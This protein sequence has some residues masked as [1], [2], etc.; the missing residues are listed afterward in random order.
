MIL[1]MSDI[2]I[3]SNLK[4]LTK[5]TRSSRS[6]EFKDILPWNISQMIIQTIPI[7][8]MVQVSW[9]FQESPELTQVLPISWIKRSS[10]NFWYSQIIFLLLRTR[11][12]LIRFMYS[13]LT[14]SDFVLSVYFPFEHLHL[15]NFLCHITMVGYRF[16]HFI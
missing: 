2:Y 8:H 7:S 9:F 15:K 3:N 1:S 13:A 11:V 12:C 4:P 5:L 6:T 10:L 14:F 16:S